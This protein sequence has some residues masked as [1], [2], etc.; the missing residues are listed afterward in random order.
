MYCG[1]KWS[2]E[3]QLSDHR[4]KGCLDAPIDPRTN[5]PICIPML[6]NFAI[7]QLSKMLKQHIE[8]NDA[9]SIQLKLHT[10]VDVCHDLNLGL[11][12]K[13]LAYKGAGRK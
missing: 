5:K 8:N 1:Q 6:P 12:T 4:S 3:L 10:Q 2:N 7:A 11:V 13:S 9:S